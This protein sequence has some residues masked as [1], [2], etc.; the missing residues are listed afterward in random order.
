M[1][2][3]LRIIAIYGSSRAHRA[4]FFMAIWFGVQIPANKKWKLAK[5]RT[6]REKAYA[7]KL[8]IIIIIIMQS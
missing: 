4:A 7:N 5:V 8:P 3:D 1:G 2:C 6:G